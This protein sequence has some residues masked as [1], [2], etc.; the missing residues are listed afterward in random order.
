V[1][2]IRCIIDYVNVLYWSHYILHAIE[3]EA[4]RVDLGLGKHSTYNIKCLAYN[5]QY[6][7]PQLKHLIGP[8]EGTRFLSE[9]DLFG[10][11]LA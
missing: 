5:I 9:L 10:T 6:K 4:K 2:Y 1:N 11:V 7:S 3:V 8:G